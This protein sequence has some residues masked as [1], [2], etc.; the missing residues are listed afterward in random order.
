MTYDPRVLASTNAATA[1]VGGTYEEYLH[2][3]NE[4]VLASPMKNSSTSAALTT[5]T[6][7]GSR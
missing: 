5:T 4:R 1:K 7:S 6:Q 2:W 3:K